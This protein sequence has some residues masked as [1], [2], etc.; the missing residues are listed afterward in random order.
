MAAIP[1][2]PTWERGAYNENGYVANNN[3]AYKRSIKLPPGKYTAIVNADYA[4]FARHY[5]SD[6]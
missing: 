6:S 1:V 3:S 2:N 4:Y 5:V